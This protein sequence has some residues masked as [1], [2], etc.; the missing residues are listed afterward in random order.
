MVNYR[1]DSNRENVIKSLLQINY[2]RAKFIDS[3][4]T[5]L[6]IVIATN[7]LKWNNIKEI[8]KRNEN[9]YSHII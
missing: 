8:T 5:K 6:K 4:K 1:Q 2:I 9:T 3:F 7:A